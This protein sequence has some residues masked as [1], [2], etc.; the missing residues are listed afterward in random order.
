[1]RNQLPTLALLLLAGCTITGCSKS[2]SGTPPS[3]PTI[4]PQATAPAPKKIDNLALFNGKAP[5]G[6]VADAT[7]GQSIRSVV[8]QAQFKCM[9]ETFN[10]MPDLVLESDGSL[11]ATL[12]GSRAEN[13]LMAYLSVNP[14]GLIDVVLRCPAEQQQMADAPFLYF[15]NRK[16]TDPT[17]KSVQ[18]WF[19]IVGQESDLIKVSDSQVTNDIKFPEF[20]KGM[21]ATAPN[22]KPI[23][24]VTHPPAPAQVA[25]GGRIAEA[26]SNIGGT[27]KCGNDRAGDFS[28]IKFLD[29][30]KLEWIDDPGSQ[31]ESKRLGKYGLNGTTLNIQ[32]TQI[33]NLA[34]LGRSPNVSIK[35]GAVIRSLNQTDLKFSWWQESE[36]SDKVNFN[37]KRQST[38]VQAL[39][40]PTPPISREAA[41]AIQRNNEIRGSAM[42]QKCQ[43]LR[44]AF[45]DTPVGQYQ[46]EKAGCI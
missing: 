34:R 42:S 5:D 14:S 38:V 11:Q 31:V 15:T 25:Q 41:D 4:V 23:A 8:P 44:N 29:N 26:S 12:S 13:W 27:W 36:P 9:S 35:E 46:L 32:I 43:M 17:P 3:A 30:E 40:L 19:Y 18:D 39:P 22:P 28:V 7:I 16:L 20:M 33:P 24:P 10:Y 2:D 1:M 21:L 6:L 37:C 45:G